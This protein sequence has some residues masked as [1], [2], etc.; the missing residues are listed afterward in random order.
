M[1][2]EPD[3]AL[4]GRLGNAVRGEL[5]KSPQAYREFVRHSHRPRVWKMDE[6]DLLLPLLWG[7]ALL[8]LPSFPQAFIVASAVLPISLGLWMAG[9]LRKRLF[10]T[11]ELVSM[12]YWP[13]SD[14]AYF[15]MQLR[16]LCLWMSPSLALFLWCGLVIR[17][18]T[19]GGNKVLDPGDLAA[20]G[21][22][23]VVQTVVMLSVGILSFC[24]AQHLPHRFIAAVCL[25]YSLATIAVSFEWTDLWVAF[26]TSG[27]W[28]LAILCFDSNAMAAAS[29]ALCICL[30][31]LAYTQYSSMQSIFRVE[32]FVLVT[33]SDPSPQ[34]A[35]RGA[36]ADR[37]AAADLPLTP[38]GVEEMKRRREQREDV[39]VPRVQQMLAAELEKASAPWA[40][41]G[42]IEHLVA[43]LLS[44]RQL[45]VANFLAAGRVRWT[46]SW[47]VALMLTLAG[48]LVW[49]PALFGVRTVLG[50]EVVDAIGDTW[51]TL[52]LAM[53]SFLLLAGTICATPVLG[54]RWTGLLPLSVG[55][56]SS[57]AY[58][59]FPIR[60]DEIMRVSFIINAIRLVLSLPLFGVQLALL[61]VAAN[62][63]FTAC[64]LQMATHGVADCMS[65][66]M[67]AFCALLMVLP[68][69]QLLHFLISQQR[70]EVMLVRLMAIALAGGSALYAAALLIFGDV[71]D[72]CLGF[73]AL[74]AVSSALVVCFAAC[75][76]RGEVDL[77]DSNP[78]TSM[79]IG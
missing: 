8:I 74:A 23:A 38:D 46:R 6:D 28:A 41:M 50:A 3:R 33:S 16:R 15:G 42:W 35:A 31:F 52:L 11:T 1:W 49:P 48:G 47:Q 30:A 55:R 75:F 68:A 67:R 45:Q 40:R 59:G 25:V 7:L 54:S 73:V 44:P 10:G 17:L 34:V 78:Q 12:A 13:L 64:S 79:G 66:G 18:N 14:Q 72:A 22:F 32:E 76:E 37:V 57:P 21:V 51:L 53:L 26:R 56:Q 29:T 9:M 65:S 63:G 70:L 2:Y 5:R 20:F 77:I 62:T 61:K 58:A 43:S 36:M 19:P 69:L 4:L 24:R 39:L 27:G 71:P 60:F